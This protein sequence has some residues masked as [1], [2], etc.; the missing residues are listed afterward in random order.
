MH[1]RTARR[2]DYRTRVARDPVLPFSSCTSN[3][4]ARPLSIV[5]D[6]MAPDSGQY[7]PSAAVKRQQMPVFLLKTLL[8]SA[9]VPPAAVGVYQ[10]VAISNPT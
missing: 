9:Y 2:K 1:G 7:C 8:G 4:V 3:P 10:D 6:T 5:N